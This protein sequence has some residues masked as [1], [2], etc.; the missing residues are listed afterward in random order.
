M[1][2]ENYAMMRNV[3]I[4]EVLCRK[5]LRADDVHAKAEAECRRGDTFK[6]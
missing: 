5:E 3:H 1:K 4:L 2:Q 6:R